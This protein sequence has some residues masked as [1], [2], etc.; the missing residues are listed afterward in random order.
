MWAVNHCN[1]PVRSPAGLHITEH[2]A[3]WLSAQRNQCILKG[4]ILTIMDM[5]NHSHIQG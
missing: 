3:G 4:A 2:K 1:A 5:Q